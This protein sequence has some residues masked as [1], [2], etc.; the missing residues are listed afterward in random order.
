MHPSAAVALAYLGCYI[1]LRM[2]MTWTIGVHG[3]RQ[4]VLW[5]E[6]PLLP[7]WDAVAFAIWAVSFTRS[8]IRWRGADYYIREGQLV[9][10]LSADGH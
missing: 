4:N 8:S 2:A 9:P 7:V 6:M 1:G 10:V 3:L 5:K